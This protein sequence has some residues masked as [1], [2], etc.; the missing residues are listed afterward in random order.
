MAKPCP[1][2]GCGALIRAEYALCSECYKRLPGTIQQS[3]FFSDDVQWHK[4]ILDE[5]LDFLNARR[6]LPTVMEATYG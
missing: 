6:P 3:A 4:A 5:A 1:V 2:R